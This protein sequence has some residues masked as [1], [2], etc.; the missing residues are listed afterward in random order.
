MVAKVEHL[1]LVEA[2]QEQSLG[3][4]LQTVLTVNYTVVEVMVLQ[5]LKIQL[6]KQEEMVLRV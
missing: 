6:Q 2:N 3:K 4:V 5:V 1:F